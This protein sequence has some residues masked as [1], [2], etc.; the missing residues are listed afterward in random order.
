MPN[1]VLEPRGEY[2]LVQYIP[3][4]KTDGGIILPDTAAGKKDHANWKVLA[5]G[6]KVKDIKKDDYILFDARSAVKLNLE[7]FP[8]DLHV[9]MID[10]VI[11]KIKTI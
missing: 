10:N 7:G 9:L 2:L 1:K 4:D 3:K 11:G 6:D 8:D 5:V